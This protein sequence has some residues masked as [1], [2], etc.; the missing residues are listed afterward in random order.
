MCTKRRMEAW[1]INRGFRGLRVSRETC[2][3]SRRQ[4]SLD[5]LICNH[6]QTLCSQHGTRIWGNIFNDGTTQ[7]ARDLPL[8][9]MGCYDLLKQLYA[10]QTKI[11]EIG[12]KDLL[13]RF[14][15]VFNG[16]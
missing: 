9:G 6:L 1:T 14:E 10:P 8:D 4:L 7:T 2:L 5:V 12:T 11:L 13:Y 3:A 16:S 15:V